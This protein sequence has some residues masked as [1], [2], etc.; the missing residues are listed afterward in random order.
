MSDTNTYIL[1]IRYIII[2]TKNIPYKL[3]RRP[4]GRGKGKGKDRGRGRGRGR[5]I[6]RVMLLF[7][8][9]RPPWPPAAAS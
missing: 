7:G 4:R 5:D 2:C 9:G 8:P 6:V 1:R 3:N